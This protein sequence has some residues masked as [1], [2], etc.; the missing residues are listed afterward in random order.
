MIGLYKGTWIIKIPHTFA[1]GQ[2]SLPNLP[3]SDSNIE[4]LKG[5]RRIK[6]GSSLENKDHV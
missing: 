4:Y 1:G 2:L 3:P 5:L 6:S